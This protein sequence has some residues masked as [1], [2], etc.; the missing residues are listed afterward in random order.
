ML[1]HGDFARG[2]SSAARQE[3]MLIDWEDAQRGGLLLHDYYHFLHMQDYL[4]GQRPTVHFTAA[5]HLAATM[6]ITAT[7][8]RKL[9]I[10]YLADSYLKCTAQQERA[11]T[12]FLLIS[13]GIALQ[14]RSRPVAVAYQEVTGRP[15][16]AGNLPTGHGSFEP[17]FSRR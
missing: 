11:H 7:Q 8:C 6:G 1:V 10:A 5:E 3:W 2:T 9:E 13:I 14:A 17:N 12:D 16:V 15:T 4:F